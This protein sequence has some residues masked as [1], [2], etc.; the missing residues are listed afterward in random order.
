MKAPLPHPT[1]SQRSP[2]AGKDH[3]GNDRYMVDTGRCFPYFAKHGFACARV[4]IR[5]TGGS[6][7]TVPDREYSEQELDDAVEVI[8][9]LAAQPWS[10]GNVG[11]WGISY[12]GFTAI[13]VAMARPPALKE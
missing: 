2:E 4:D 12:G 8:R 9:Q 5:G 3:L 10:N 11:M 13:Q 6:E 1:S 7:G